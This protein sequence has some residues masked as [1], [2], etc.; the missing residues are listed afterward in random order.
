MIAIDHAHALAPSGRRSPAVVDDDGDRTGAVRAPLRASGLS[1]GSASAKMTAAAASRRMSSS[2]H[3]EAA[4]V[5][6]WFSRPTRMRVGGNVDLVRARRNRAQQPIDD[7]QR[8]QRRE[9][10]G[11]EERESAEAH[12]CA[13]SG[14]GIRRLP[15]QRWSPP[16]PCMRMM[17][18]EQ[19]L[20]WRA[21]GVMHEERPAETLGESLRAR[22]GAPRVCAWYCARRLCTRSATQRWPPFGLRNSVRPS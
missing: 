10:P 2:H 12:R 21:I 22:R 8:C 19:R 18:V 5:F 9:Q 16:P 13:S 4:G 3:G 6:S 17:S 11:I 14:R 1:T 20:G 7:R 15:C